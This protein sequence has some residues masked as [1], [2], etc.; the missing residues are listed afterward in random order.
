[1]CV[2][3]GDIPRVALLIDLEMQI[4]KHGRG[5]AEADMPLNVF[6]EVS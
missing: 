1:M 3:R 2:D 4:V 6:L 5:V